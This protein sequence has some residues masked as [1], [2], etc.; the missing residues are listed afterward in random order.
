VAGDQGAEYGVAWDPDLKRWTKF[1]AAYKKCIAIRGK[2]LAEIREARSNGERLTIARKSIV[3]GIQP[4]NE[5]WGDAKRELCYGV[6]VNDAKYE[7]KVKIK[8]FHASKSRAI[9]WKFSQLASKEHDL[10]LQEQLKA[11]RTSGPDAIAQDLHRKAAK[12][13]KEVSAISGG[14]GYPSHSSRCERVAKLL[15]QRKLYKVEGKTLQP[16][17]RHLYRRRSK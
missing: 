12:V 7:P 17:L 11:G 10:E 5:K 2:M 3:F 16:V 13:Y 4:F 15:K 6:S 1:L 9:L 14:L 8:F